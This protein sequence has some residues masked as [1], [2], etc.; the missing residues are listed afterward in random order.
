MLARLNPLIVVRAHWRSLEI[1]TPTSRSSDTAAKVILLGVPTTVGALAFFSDLELQSPGVLVS[2]LS[3]FSA[4][5]LAAFAQLASIRSRYPA[6][7][8]AWD[9]ERLTR[10]MLD[11]AIAHILTAALISVTTAVLVIVGMNVGDAAGQSI[12][13]WFSIVVSVFG[14]YMFLVFIMTIRKLFGAY[15]SA[16]Q[17]DLRKVGK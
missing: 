3:L 10:E 11:E 6:P 15:V 14:I 13:Q 1:R 9:P 12:N 5:L 16:N 7:T 2:A 8:E 17:I 4:G